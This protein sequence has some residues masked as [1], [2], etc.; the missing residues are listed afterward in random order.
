MWKF[1]YDQ[2][3]TLFQFVYLSIID[4]PPK[5]LRFSFSQDK[6]IIKRSA[7]VYDRYDL[8]VGRERVFF[9][10]GWETLQLPMVCMGPNCLNQLW[11]STS[12]SISTTVPSLLHE[13][14]VCLLKKPLTKIHQ[15]F[16]AETR[17]S[18]VFHLSTQNA[19]PGVHQRT[20][21]VTVVRLSMTDSKHTWRLQRHSDSSFCGFSGSCGS[22]LV[23]SKAYRNVAYF[24]FNS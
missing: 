6:K 5:F 16:H 14:K 23:W 3:V 10:G 9:G 13:F 11:Y 15:G 19:W 20:A 18:N 17:A 22:D 8:T 7:G 24:I 4:V 12:Y 1:C 21:A 2:K